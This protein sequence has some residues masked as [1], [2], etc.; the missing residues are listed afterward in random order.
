MLLSKY[1]A[2]LL[3]PFFFATDFALSH[4][5]QPDQ[6]GGPDEAFWQGLRHWPVAPRHG[7]PP[8]LGRIRIPDWRICTAIGP[9]AHPAG[10]AVLS[11]GGLSVSAIPVAA[12]V[13]PDG[14]AFQHGLVYYFLVVCLIKIPVAILIL[15]AGLVLARRKLGMIWRPDEL[16]LVMPFVLM[17]IY[18]SF[19]NTIPKWVPLS[20]A[21]YPLLFHLARQLWSGPA[22]ERRHANRRWFPGLLDHCRHTPDLA[23]LPCVFQ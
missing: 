21:V 11:R 16:Y 22:A 13:F 8:G 3:L 23:R 19:F 5:G 6:T 18:L 12:F 10:R 2:L 20:S 9:V 1:T 14:H 17:F 15:L 7:F 4:R